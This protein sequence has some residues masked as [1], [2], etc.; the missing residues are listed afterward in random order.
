MLRFIGLILLLISTLSFA[1]AEHCV[2]NLAAYASGNTLDLRRCSIM[3]SGDIAVIAN[4]LQLNPSLTSLIIPKDENT[5]FGYLNNDNVKYLINVQTL[6]SLDLSG[7][8]NINTTN[9]IELIAGSKTLKSL[10][11]SWDFLTPNAINALAQNKSIETLNLTQI[12]SVKASDLVVFGKN[13]SLKTLILYSTQIDDNVVQA[14]SNSPTLESV[15]LGHPDAEAQVSESTWLAFVSNKHLKNIAIVDQH[16]TLPVIQQL[17]A[18]KNLTYLR[19]IDDHIN[20]QAISYLKDIPNLHTLIVDK[21]NISDIG[22]Q[23]IAENT[24]IRALSLE[25]NPITESGVIAFAKQ[26]RATML[27]FSGDLGITPESL[28]AILAIPGL[29]SLDVAQ[30]GVNDE[31]TAQLVRLHLQCLNVK[32]NHITSIGAKYFANDAKLGTLALFGNEFSQDD[33]NAIKHNKNI[34]EV[35]DDNWVMIFPSCLESN[36]G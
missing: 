13:A 28:Q 33:I 31:M 9:V 2:N 27:D 24:A 29:T 16:L 30:T 19:L 7:I 4:Y 1:G 21:N 12:L 15:Y 35:I 3:S 17:S 26:T 14:L 11:I 36:V 20:D 22:L 6:Q 5:E 23:A 10:D 25:F 8:W 32:K 18:N 34:N